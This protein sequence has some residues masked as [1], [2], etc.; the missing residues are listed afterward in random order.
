[1]I[2]FSK[3]L[4]SI[5][6]NT[7]IDE[8]MTRRILIIVFGFIETILGFR[9]IF[10]LAGANPTNSLIKILYDVT[11]DFVGV[12]ESIFSPTINEGLETIAVIE[13]GTIIAMIV[14]ALIALAI[15][16]FFTQ[17]KRIQKHTTQYSI[18]DQSLSNKKEEI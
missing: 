15:S 4:E 11:N 9:F 10:K 5:N 13:P 8:S 2:E 18:A 1:M 12:F 6:T 3:K 16:K 7:H 17:D 14:F